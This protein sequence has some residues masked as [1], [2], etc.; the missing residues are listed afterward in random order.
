MSRMQ[1]GTFTCDSIGELGRLSHCTMTRRHLSAA[2]ASYLA[3]AACG[4]PDAQPSMEIEERIVDITCGSEY[5]WGYLFEGVD[6]AAARDFRN[7]N[8]SIMPI[9]P[10]GGLV[11]GKCNDFPFG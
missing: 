11:A 2:V 7:D 9:T 8:V 6:R 10:D 4:Y 3:F 1:F 5:A